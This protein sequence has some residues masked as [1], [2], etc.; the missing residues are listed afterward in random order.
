MENYHDQQVTNAN[1]QRGFMSS[2]QIVMSFIKRL[3]NEFK[4]TKQD[5]IDAGVYFRG[6]YEFLLY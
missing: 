2:L 6:V 3:I 1:I 5:L 4:V